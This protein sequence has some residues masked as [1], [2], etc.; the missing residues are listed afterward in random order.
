MAAPVLD[1]QVYTA[2]ANLDLSTVTGSSNVWDA[3]DGDIGSDWYK[4]EYF[5]TLRR[6]RFGGA[7]LTPVPFDDAGGV[8]GNFV[9]NSKQFYATNVDRFDIDATNTTPAQMAFNTIVT[10]FQTTP[11]NKIDWGIRWQIEADQKLRELVLINDVYFYGGASWTFKAS[12]GD[13]SVADKT[14]AMPSNNYGGFQSGDATIKCVYRS[15]V[16]TLITLELRR[17]AGSGAES[18]AAPIAGYLRMPINPPQPGKYKQLVRTRQGY[19][20]A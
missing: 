6:K 12:L 20:R 13:S 16:P 5:D 3:Y 4:W 17:I 15:V 11:T 19:A 10:G 14:I 7:R 2:P 9:G 8:V 18:S 1:L